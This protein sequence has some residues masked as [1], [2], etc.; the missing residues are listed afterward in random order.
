MPSRT[1]SHNRRRRNHK[2][3]K[4]HTISAKHLEQQS[5]RDNF[6]IWAN[7]KWIKDVPKTIPKDMRYIRP[8]DNFALIQ[9]D[10][11]KNVNSMID[12]YIKEHG[13]PTKCE[14]KAREFH[15][16]YKSFVTLDKEPV[17]CHIENYCKTYDNMVQENNIWKF[18]G[19]INQN[20]IRRRR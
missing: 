17:L 8:L 16:L 4:A 3:R 14:G 11:Y 19:Y 5:Q 20:E 7:Y 12:E 15:N 1:E 10:T 2:K 9:D 6:Y 13:G 18:L